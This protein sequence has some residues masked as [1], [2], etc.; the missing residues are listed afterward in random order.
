MVLKIILGFS[1]K[2]DYFLPGKS[3]SLYDFDSNTKQDFNLL[4]C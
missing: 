4:F 1:P 2:L 3:L